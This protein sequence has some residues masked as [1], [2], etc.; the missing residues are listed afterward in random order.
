[1]R[2]PLWAVILGLLLTSCTG[3]VKPTR[4]GLAPLAQV[5]IK[6]G[7]L[8]L[9]DKD[10]ASALT[11]FENALK[12]QPTNTDALVGRGRANTGL[13]KYDEAIA[14]FS[15]VPEGDPNWG[16]AHRYRCLAYAA[17]EAI[18]QAEADLE[19][20]KRYAPE[21]TNIAQEVGEVYA[22][23]ACYY[24]KAQEYSKAKH[25]YERALELDPER[26]DY[27]HQ[28]AILYA[29]MRDWTRAIDEYNK[30]VQYGDPANSVALP[31][32]AAYLEQARS[33]KK[34]NQPEQA[35]TAFREAL[36]LNPNFRIYKPEFQ[37]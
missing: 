4:G 16:P 11:C 28:A 33:F 7:Q 36:R 13:G 35:K 1:M 26:A 6:K 2:F 3:K 20:A 21:G 34:Q 24:R 10:Y 31:L 14:D 30:A 37:Q 18:P 5:N 15:A 19:I 12:E 9:K 8:Y 22:Q 17:N 29:S 27:H 25:Y 23:K 32:A